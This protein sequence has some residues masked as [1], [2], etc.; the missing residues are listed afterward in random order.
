MRYKILKNDNLLGII[1]IID[2][3]GE[4]SIKLRTLSDE[5][6][7][8][9]KIKATLQQIR[10]D[11]TN[12]SKV[13]EGKDILYKLIEGGYKVDEAIDGD[14][15]LQ[16][17]LTSEGN[18]IGTSTPLLPINDRDLGESI[19]RN[20]IHNLKSK[21]MEKACQLAKEIKQLTSH[22]NHTEAAKLVL[23]PELSVLHYMG[24]KLPESFI[25]AFFLIDRVKVDSDII[26]EFLLNR[27]A[28]VQD[29]DGASRAEDDAKWLL[30]NKGDLDPN[31]SFNL[32]LVIG[33][34]LASKKLWTS[35]ENQYFMA[36]QDANGV[37]SS[38]KAWAYYNTGTALYNQGRF[39]E[40]LKAYCQAGD[41]WLSCKNTEKAI[42]AYM[43]KIKFDE[44]ENKMQA[45]S[46][47]EEVLLHVSNH[48]HAP[49]KD[50]VLAHILGYL[51][52]HKAQLLYDLG[53]CPETEQ[54]LLM[55]YENRK[56]IIGLE[57]E[58]RATIAFLELVCKSLGKI[59]H[60]KRWHNEWLKLKTFDDDPNLEFKEKILGLLNSNKCPITDFQCLENEIKNTNNDLLLL[61]F[62]V[63]IV[64]KIRIEN[65]VKALEFLDKAFLLGFDDKSKEIC[66]IYQMYAEIM[67]QLDR[68]PEAYEYLKKAFKAR[69]DER[70][71]YPNL[72]YY[73][74]KFSKSEDIFEFASKWVIC[75]EQNPVAWF[76]LGSCHEEKR[77]NRDAYKAYGKALALA[78]NEEKNIK[79][80]INRVMDKIME[81]SEVTV[82]NIPQAVDFLGGNSSEEIL[83]IENKILSYL[84]NF[85][86]QIEKFNIKDFW[87]QEN[88]KSKW[89]SRPEQQA[90]ILLLLYL[91]A[92]FNPNVEVLEEV[93]IDEGRMDI[94]ILIPPGIKVV[95]ELKM[96]GVGYSSTYA[97]GAINQI[98]TYMEKKDCSIGFIIIFDARSRDQGIGFEE[99]YRNNNKSAKTIIINVSHRTPSKKSTLKE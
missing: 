21:S 46:N 37:D 64:T 56:D 14:Y 38:S 30:E 26:E 87:I 52:F 45:L 40:S 73:A 7:E 28:M 53:K 83:T 59:N 17:V 10:I 35:A 95:F 36:L 15:Q 2:N 41:L 78:P 3:E 50:I 80:S 51:F 65:P 55:S 69:T 39:K 22:G 12:L 24:G 5:T 6:E 48:K 58:T 68:L 76:I 34:A 89:I 63:T 60:S 42:M 23:S 1:Q 96:C 72:I 13:I 70:A 31:L 29:Y 85:K 79:Q 81:S 77:N 20:L 32:K 44:N 74:Q 90:Q 8:I 54:A 4:F 9:E 67:Q 33:N 19:G 25:E 92:I 47:I 43:R 62:Y 93:V 82:K 91:R 88:G 11:S 99:V 71:L 86:K 84:N 97:R 49:M 57:S 16:I 18:N 61:S 98:F 75:E 27:V 66:I 94:Y